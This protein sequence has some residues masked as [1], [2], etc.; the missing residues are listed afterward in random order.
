MLYKEPKMKRKLLFASLLFG[1]VASLGAQAK[2]EPTSSLPV[3][4]G[5][6]A[7]NEYQ[8]NSDVSGMSLGA[9]LGT[10]G[11]LYLAIQA[12]TSGWVALG[13]G[14]SRMDGSRLF[15]AYDTGSKQVFNEQRGMGHSHKDVSDAVVEKWSVK[16]LGGNT[17]LELVLPASAAVVDGKLGLLFAYSGSTSYIMPHK[18]RGSLSLS[19]GK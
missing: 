13:V 5:K 15:L 2:L 6:V 1:L 7:A 14:G 8:F 4:D 10:D 12:K 3:P 16:A 11:K 9:T 18:A 17:T 19:I